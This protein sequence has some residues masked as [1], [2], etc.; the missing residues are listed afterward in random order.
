M[1]ASLGRDTNTE[2]AFREKTRPEV[3]KQT[4]QIIAPLQ[5]SDSVLSIASEKRKKSEDIMV[6]Q[7]GKLKRNKK[8]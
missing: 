4:G 1:R 6:I 8:N 3:I 5:L 7:G 2:S